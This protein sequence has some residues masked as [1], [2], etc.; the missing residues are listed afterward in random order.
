[1]FWIVFHLGWTDDSERAWAHD[2][3]KARRDRRGLD[4]VRARLRRGTTDSGD[5][6]RCGSR[7]SCATA[8]NTT[9]RVGVAVRAV[10]AQRRWCAAAARQQ[11]MCAEQFGWESA[12]SSTEGEKSSGREREKAQ[13]PFY[14]RGRGEMRGRPAMASSCH[15]RRLWREGLMGK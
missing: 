15:Q 3:A 6:A 7:R 10:E 2:K 14:R 12:E 9:T 11:S 4:G 8:G 1:M 13:R 5:G